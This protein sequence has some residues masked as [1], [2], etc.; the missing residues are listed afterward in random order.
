M[1]RSIPST[2]Q[3][4]S[5]DTTDVSPAPSEHGHPAGTTVTITMGAE[6]FAP[7]QY[8]TFDV[9]PFSAT[10]T[11]QPGE[12]IKAAYDRVM[13]ELRVIFKAEFETRLRE[14]LERVKAGGAAARSGR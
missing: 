13:G 4:G 9:G 5:L 8:Q 2:E 12:T 1:R 11:L 10:T 3:P 14:H 7:V 6:K